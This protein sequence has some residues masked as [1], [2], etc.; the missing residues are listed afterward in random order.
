M[1]FS[2][3]IAAFDS[4]QTT[5]IVFINKIYEILKNKLFYLAVLVFNC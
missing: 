4:M 3:T 1:D 5:N 2:E